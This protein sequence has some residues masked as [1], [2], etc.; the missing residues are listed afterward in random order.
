MAGKAGHPV[1]HKYT[2]A[3]LDVGHSGAGFHHHARRLMAEGAG[4]GDI[5]AD[6]VAAAHPAGIGFEEYFTVA[7]LRNRDIDDFRLADLLVHNRCFHVQDPPD[8]KVSRNNV[9]RL[10]ICSIS[11]FYD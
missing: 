4:P 7:D 8:E 10:T 9:N 3:L 11:A 2:V 5:P 1:M 6:D